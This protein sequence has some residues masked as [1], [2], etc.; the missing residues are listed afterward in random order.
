MSKFN[1]RKPQYDEN[2]K[3]LKASILLF[4]FLSFSTGV[5]LLAIL[6]I[7]NAPFMGSVSWLGIEEAPILA[8]ALGMF[9]LTC[10]PLIIDEGRNQRDWFAI[11]YLI[12]VAYTLNF[13]LRAFYILAYPESTRATLIFTDTLDRVLAYVIAGIVLLFIGYY[14]PLGM[15]L[16][17]R[18]PDLPFRWPT[19]VGLGKVMIIYVIGFA[20]RWI[21]SLRVAPVELSYYAIAFGQFTSYALALAAIY[22]FMP[23]SGKRRWRLL[24]AVLLPLQAIYAMD[25]G[26]DKFSLIEPIVIMLMCYHYL[27][28][29]LNIWSLAPVGLLVIT[30][31]F[32]Y[33]SLYRSQPLSQDTRAG[34]FQAC[35]DMIALNWQEYSNLVLESVMGRAHLL[36]SV[37]LVVKY[38]SHIGGFLGAEDY[39]LIPVYAFLPRVVW[40]DKPID[41]ALT[42]GIDFFATG[43]ATYIGIS[44][45]GDLYRHLGIGGI[46]GGMFILGLLYRFSY[47][48]LIKIR[49]NADWSLRVPFL[50]FYIFVFIQLYLTFETDLSSGISE[51]IKRILFL[52]LLAWYINGRRI[53]YG[54]DQKLGES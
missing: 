48:Y 46:L 45:P 20:A 23:G 39:L 19:S 13:A 44:N 41:R 34:I 52:A 31:V 35:T 11:I 7:L 17:K 40:P 3:R 9:G 42:F 24:I 4:G 51:L 10:V 26:R 32:P 16:A 28:G 1:M 37:A 22:S 27:R 29:R 15:K 2:P 36:D 12:S 47:E 5:G 53:M 50:F 38:T 30:L 21:T 43:G 14:L 25:W 6:I 49:L 18:F 33:M 8:L 54:N